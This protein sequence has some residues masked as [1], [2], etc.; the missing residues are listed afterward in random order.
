MPFLW[1]AARVRQSQVWAARGRAKAP[2]PG[3]LAITLGLPTFLGDDLAAL[4]TAARQNLGLFTTS[5]SSIGSFGPAALQKR[6]CK[7]N[8]G[9]E[10][11]R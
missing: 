7:W 1:P 5:P 2:T 6:R 8:R 3:P 10:P 9:L 11:P 4:R